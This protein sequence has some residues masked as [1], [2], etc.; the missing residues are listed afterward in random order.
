MKN[1][2]VG[3]YEIMHTCTCPKSTQ[4]HFIAIHSNDDST[5]KLK[6]KIEIENRKSKIEN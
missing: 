2:N 6:L 3:A 5:S 1:K 4:S